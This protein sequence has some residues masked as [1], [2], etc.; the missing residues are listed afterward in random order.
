MLFKYWIKQELLFIRMLDFLLFKKTFFDISYLTYDMEF[1]LWRN[2]LIGLVLTSKQPILLFTDGKNCDL[3]WNRLRKNFEIFFF[4]CMQI[5][6]RNH[7]LY[8]NRCQST[9]ILNFWRDKISLKTILPSL[10]PAKSVNF[11]VSA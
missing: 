5:K 7:F 8:V 11:I 1:K 9:R 10:G 6:Q 2:L 3:V 4:V